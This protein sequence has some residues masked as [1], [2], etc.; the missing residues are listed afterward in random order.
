MKWVS[1][2]L[3]KDGF[4]FQRKHVKDTMPLLNV[5]YNYIERVHVQ[6]DPT[7][8]LW[9]CITTVKATV[10]TEQVGYIVQLWILRR[11]KGLW[12]AMKL[13]NIIVCTSCTQF[14]HF[15][16]WIELVAVNRAHLKKNERIKKYL[17]KAR[18]AWM[19]EKKVRLTVGKG[20]KNKKIKKEYTCRKGTQG[21]NKKRQ[22]GRK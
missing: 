1:I 9:V 16:N 2:N 21:K 6:K 13:G 12:T 22:E 7:V 17:Y 19:E 20:E 4:Q 14:Q 11:E 5:Q 10:A 8:I 3:G 18:A 15:S